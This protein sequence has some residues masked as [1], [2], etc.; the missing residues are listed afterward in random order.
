M[1]RQ[2]MNSPRWFTAH[3]GIRKPQY[4]LP[5]IDFDLNAD[6]P[7]YIDPYAITQD[8][9]LLAAHCHDDIVSYFQSLLDAVRAQD[10]RR[11]RYLLSGRLAEPK[12]IHLGVGKH[13]RSGAGIGPLQESQIIEALTGSQALRTGLIQS[14][15]ELEL[16]IEGIGPD[17]ISDLVGNII[18]GRLAEF[19]SW[20][21]RQYGIPTRQCA[22]N[23][24]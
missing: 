16:H 21:C 3:F 11:I 9:S 13:A 7:L 1:N 19:T 8:N 15:Q 18:K 23:A 20:V 5:F 6:V 2:A 4:E 22:V 14:I 24:C 12:E 10:E 17:K